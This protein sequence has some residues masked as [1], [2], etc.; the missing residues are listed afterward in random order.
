MFLGTVL[1]F[2]DRLSTRRSPRLGAIVTVATLS[3]AGY[4]AAVFTRWPT[5]GDRQPPWS[6]HRRLGIGARLARTA[7][8][9]SAHFEALLPH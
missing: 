5:M 8:P 2:G 3:A 1:W 9:G 4:G 7:T 6:D